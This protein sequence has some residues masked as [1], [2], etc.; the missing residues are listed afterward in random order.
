MRKGLL[1]VTVVGVSLA[2]GLAGCS[3]G[4]ST[5]KASGGA[6]SSS[7]SGGTL[8]KVGIIL[9]DMVSSP[10]WVSSDPSA[11]ATDCKKA[12]ITCY[13]DN[14]HGDANQMKTIAEQD[15]AKGI[16]ILMI[17]NLDNQSGAAIEKQPN[18]EGITTID[19][20]RLTLGGSDTLYVSYDG[21][22]V[23]QAQGTALTQ[24]PQV[25]GKSSVNYV[26]VDGAPTDNNATLFK[27]GYV[28]VLSKTPG[29]H[30][31]DDQAVPNWDPTQANTIFANMLASHP[32]INAVMVANDTMAGSVIAVLKKNNLAGKVAVSGQDDAAQGIQQVLSGDQCFTIY[33][34]TAGEAGPAVQAMV[35]I[36]KGQTP[37]T[38]GTTKDTTTGKEV[39]SI[40]ATPTVVTL[41]NIDQPFK[42]GYVTYADVCKGSYVALCQKYGIT[43]NS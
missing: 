29:W 39:P 9:P 6:S 28:S 25:K 11:L 36:L 13:I 21:V 24:C 2:L 7:S 19:Y 32:N 42:D 41:A 23:G 30:L 18:A 40:L 27:Q 8:G 26:Q 34:P 37:T 3:S 10:R 35:Q 43:P 4:K 31:L 12:N 1:G 14:A 38:N 17:V 5:S 22:K 33:K 20:D 16:K 15:E